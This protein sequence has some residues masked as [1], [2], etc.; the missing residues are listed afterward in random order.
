[1]INNDEK[2]NKHDMPHHLLIHLFV[3]FPTYVALN[4][5]NYMPILL[6]KT[7]LSLFDWQF[8]MLFGW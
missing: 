6:E 4:N 8:F 2:T 5:K 7:N 1:M 3:G